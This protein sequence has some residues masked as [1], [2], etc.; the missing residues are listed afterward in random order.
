MTVVEK[1]IKG[2]IKTPLTCWRDG[3]PTTKDKMRQ[4]YSSCVMIFI[5]ELSAAS[6]SSCLRRAAYPR[7]I[8]RNMGTTAVKIKLV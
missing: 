6:V 1:P 5:R 8:M 2:G 7:N 3:L 4:G